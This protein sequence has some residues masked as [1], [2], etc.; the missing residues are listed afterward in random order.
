M[1]NP[2]FLPPVL[3]EP[4]LYLGGEGRTP[5]FRIPRPLRPWL[6]DPGSLTRRL[7][8]ESDGEFRVQVLDQGHSSSRP[9]ERN[10]LH[11]HHR[12]WPFVR[13]VYLVCRGQPW[14]YARTLI[15]VDTLQGPAR[16]LTHL[17]SKPLGAVLFNHPRVRRGPISVYCVRADRLHP[18]LADQGLLWGRQS[19]FYLFDKPLLVS[20]YFLQDCPMYAA[21][22]ST[23]T[24]DPIQRNP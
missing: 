18:A 3:H 1:S 5:P 23:A 9:H 4:A 7:I 12:A 17:G 13:E 15:P 20:E 10:A 11:L 22:P 2:P 19:L 24:S 16:A 8:Q 6:L 14:V 21:L